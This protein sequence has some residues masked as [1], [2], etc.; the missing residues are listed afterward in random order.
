MIF[1][2]NSLKFI[3][4]DDQLLAYFLTLAQMSD[5]IIGCSITPLQKAEII[6]QV[7]NFNHNTNNYVMSI[8]ACAED[9]NMITEADVSIGIST[10]YK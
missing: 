9:V 8:V 7:K 5:F 3:N 6:K 10:R 4:R 1:N 2:G